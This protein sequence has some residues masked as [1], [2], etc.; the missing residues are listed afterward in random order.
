[1]NEQTKLHGE[2]ELGDRGGG[3]ASRNSTVYFRSGPAFITHL[4]EVK[5]PDF[6]A[7]IFG[8]RFTSITN[9]PAS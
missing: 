7:A 1:M 4:H 3:A 9:R 5:L 2:A 8:D 6:V